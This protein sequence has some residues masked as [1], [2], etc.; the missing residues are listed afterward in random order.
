MNKCVKLQ[1]TDTESAS[2]IFSDKGNG[3]TLLVHAL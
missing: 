2:E 1:N 3:N